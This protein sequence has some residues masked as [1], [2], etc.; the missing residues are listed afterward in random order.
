[1]AAVATKPADQSN[2]VCSSS[3]SRCVSL[4]DPSNLF[5]IVPAHGTISATTAL[6]L[7]IPPP[8]PSSHFGSITSSCP[9]LSEPAA[10]LHSAMVSMFSLVVRR[11]SH[12]ADLRRVCLRL[13][14]GLG[15]WT[16]VDRMLT[17]NE[18]CEVRGARRN[19]CRSEQ[20]YG[21]LRNS[22]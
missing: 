12:R 22:C 11:F 9:P 18:Y 16:R 21:Q 17:W 19:H 4:V 6:W 8:V 13:G 5:P 20:A 15:R 14:T 7:R 2:S 10:V 3:L 1:M